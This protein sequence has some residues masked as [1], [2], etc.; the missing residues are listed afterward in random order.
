MRLIAGMAV[1]ALAL[2]VGLSA[3]SVAPSG[4]PATIVTVD[5]EPIT[6]ADLDRARS[7]TDSTPLGRLLVDLVDEQLLAQRGKNL[8]Y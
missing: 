5:R 7:A 4:S 2:S 3:Q 6:Q 1:S 8:G